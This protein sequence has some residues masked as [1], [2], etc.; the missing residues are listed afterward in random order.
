MR[1][2]RRVWIHCHTK[3]AERQLQEDAVT[4]VLSWA[5]GVEAEGQKEQ[6]GVAYFWSQIL[7]ISHGCKEFGHYSLCK[8]SKH[9]KDVA[10]IHTV[11]AMKS[12]AERL[13][14]WEE[15]QICWGVIAQAAENA[16][17]PSSVLSFLF[18]YS[19]H[20]ESND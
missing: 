5:C 10:E 16:F 17:R 12:F 15:V 13:A 8:D 19:S 14:L 20:G 18:A 6:E 11:E 4:Q 9:R 2:D 1:V 7:G 3:F